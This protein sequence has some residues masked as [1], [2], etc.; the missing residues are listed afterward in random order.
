MEMTDELFLESGFR[1]FAP[2]PLDSR[3]VERCFQKRYDDE[4]GKKYFITVRKWSEQRHPHTGTVFPECYE[5]D[6]QL[7]HGEDKGD[8][9]DLKFHSSW[10]LDDVEETL[11]RIWNL[12]C[13]EY[14]ERFE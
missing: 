7:Y 9:L 5:Y 6:V 11:E 1:E 8:A 14:Y 3:G 4:D 13:F 2:G 12:G 10:T